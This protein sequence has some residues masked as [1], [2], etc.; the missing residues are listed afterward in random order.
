MFMLDCNYFIIRARGAIEMSKGVTPMSRRWNFPNWLAPVLWLGLTA[1]SSG[2]TTANPATGQSEF[3][4]F[5]SPAKEREVGAQAHPDVVKENGGVYDNPEL[6]GYVATVGGRLAAN[7]EMKDLSFTFTVL[8]TSLVNAFA[9]PGGYVYITRGILAQFNSEAELA[10]VLGHEIGHVTA[11]H[12]AKRYN[13]QMFA[14]I[15]GAGLGAVTGSSYVTD[16]LGYGSQLYLLGYSRDQ[17]YQAD[18]LGVR[19]ATRAGYDPYAAADMLHMLGVQAELAAL[20]ANKEGRERLPEFF[21][22]HPNSENR[23]VRATELARQ[24]GVQPGERPRVRD[25]FLGEINGMLYGDDPAQGLLRGRTFWHPELKFTFTV[26]EGFQMTN[27]SDA[28]VAKGP[29]GT[30]VLFTGGEVEPTDKTAD[31][32]QQAWKKIA[33][34]RAISNIDQ[35]EI[36]G[37]EAHTGSTQ[38]VS[39]GKN[40]I[41]RIIAIRYSPDRAFHFAIIEPVEQATALD[42]GLR[43]MTY[44][45]RKISD[46]EARKIKPRR[47]AVVAVKKGD[48][49]QS[50]AKRMDYEDYQLERFLALN[51]MAKGAE[52]KPGDQVK[53]IVSE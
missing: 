11:R 2:C 13:R 14:G 48:T 6:A 16:L 46:A 38:A 42:E 41:V 35:F 1:L 26:P 44:S 4:P 22:T 24:T 36:N 49:A 33:G 21:A 47:I 45:F 17:E 8:N 25:K 10:S 27:S 5:M 50:M 52:V 31:Y 18:G 30:A 51:G 43:R 39:S 19:Y 29:G 40:V 37:M 23:V 15:L 3:T 7:S 53:L 32:M 12:T 20:V 28:L 9:L 34:E